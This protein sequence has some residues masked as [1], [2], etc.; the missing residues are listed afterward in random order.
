MSVG[1]TDVLFGQAYFLRFDPKLWEAQQPYAPLGAL[2]AAA[3]A[4][5]R[6]YSVAFFDAMLAVS[7]AEWAAALDRHRPRVAVLYEDS[8]NYL[9]KMCLLRMREAALTMIDAARERGVPVIVAGSDASDHPVVY[10]D[11]G[12][13]LVVTGEGEITLGDVLDS[14]SGRTQQQLTAIPG[15]CL[16]GI[17]GRVV[18]TP[19]RE[20]IRDL[21]GLPRPAWDLV[22]VEAYRRVWMARHG[23]F[24]M[25]VVTTRG[26]PYHCNW[27]AKPIYGQR[28]SARSAEGVAAEVAWLK[29]T[30]HPDH[31]W[32]ADDIFGLRPGWIDQYAAAVNTLKAATPFKC[33]L[34]ADGV[35][36]E[37]AR[38]LAAAGC[39]TAWVGAESGSQD[40]LDAMEKGTRVGHIYDAARLLKAAGVRVGFFLQ[41]GYPGET[42]AHIEQ[43]LQMVRECAPDDIGVSVSYPLPGTPFYDR[44]KAQL[45][46]KQNWLDSSDLAM[47]YQA[48][49]V[50]E[51]Y[52]VL[53]A[54][55]HAEFRSKKRGTVRAMAA[56]V[57]HSIRIPILRHRIERLSRVHTHN[58]APLLLIPV[59]SRQAAAMPSEQSH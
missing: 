36:P 40:V 55:V 7:E 20:I 1:T 41:F 35:T 31:V 9:S 49:Y 12:A 28:Y 6:G 29:D 5:E 58:P 51:F 4:R 44:V 13:V 23:Y 37:S 15:V 10:L 25:N 47:M 43:T 38:T 24:S 2:Y 54:L 42:L 19:A 59:L 32:F 57:Y 22:D 18:R 8:F 46:T 45:G 53:H 50:P 33:L 52:R 27:C 26:C 56:S 11:R 17:D 48:A 21:D 14:M 30:Y 39:Q 34:R 3:A 16:R